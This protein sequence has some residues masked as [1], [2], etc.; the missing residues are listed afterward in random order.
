MNGFQSRVYRA[1]AQMVIGLL[2]VTQIVVLFPVTG[3]KAAPSASL[4]I[5]EI[6]L[7][8]SGS[9][10]SHNEFVELYNKSPLDIN[11]SGWSL[12]KAA[13]AGSSETNVITF[14]AGTVVNANDSL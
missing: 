7:G 8:E 2:A 11:I 1:V 6:Q 4:V 12:K 3:A 14:P 5:N 13:E 10:N 9:G